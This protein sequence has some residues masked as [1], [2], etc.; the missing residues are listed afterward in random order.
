MHDTALLDQLSEDIGIAR[1]L[2]ELADEEF[3][4]LSERDLARLQAILARKQPLLALLAQHGAQRSQYLSAHR[5]SADAAGLQAL[6]ARSAQGSELLARAG[7][8]DT[9]LQDCRNANERNGRLI[10]ANRSAV[11]GLLDVLQ[12]TQETPNL[13]DNRGGAARVSR[14]RPLSQA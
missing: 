4:A 1:S 5:L 9:L 12:G 14:P 8:L 11:A 3:T 7:T 6:A 10:R 2:L 13:Y